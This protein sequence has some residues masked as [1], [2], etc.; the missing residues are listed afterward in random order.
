M[1]CLTAGQPCPPG[2]RGHCSLR[3]QERKTRPPTGIFRS[4]HLRD[5]MYFFTHEAVP[6]CPQ[7]PGSSTP[8]A[9]KPWGT[10]AWA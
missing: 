7:G 1:S 10:E 4:E 9:R 6:L 8:G 3:P 2:E 5:Y